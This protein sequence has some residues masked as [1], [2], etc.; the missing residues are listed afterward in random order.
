MPLQGFGI[1]PAGTHLLH[2][3]R[4][5]LLKS[6]QGKMNGLVLPPVVQLDVPGAG[7]CMG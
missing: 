6:G 1:A 3:G 7:T 4:Y 2:I 5:G